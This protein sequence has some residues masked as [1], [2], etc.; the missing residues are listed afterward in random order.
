MDYRLIVKHG[1]DIGKIFYIEKNR[2]IIGRDRNT[3]IAVN[4]NT[5]SR[6]HC[7][8]SFLDDKIILKDIQSTNKSRVNN[9]I[10]NNEYLLKNG[11][12]IALGQTTLCLEQVKKAPVLSNGK[13]E[14]LSPPTLLMDNRRV[15]IK[16]IS[17]N[18]DL[19]YNVNS[20]IHSIRDKKKLIRIL[21]ELVFD[22]IPAEHGAILIYDSDL[23]KLV[24]QVGLSRKTGITEDIHISYSIAEMTFNKKIGIITSDALNDP[25]FSNKKTII[26]RSI[27]SA[28]CAPIG[29][30]NKMI[31]VIHLD[32]H[33]ETG[34]F[35]E[36]DLDLLSVIANQA[37][38]ALEN[39]NFFQ[40]LNEKN[41][42]LQKAM[43]KKYNMIGKSKRIKDI[44]AVIDRLSQNE[45]TILI[46]G[47][48]GTGKELVARAIHYTSIR[49]NKS[50]VCVNCAALNKNLLESEL[51]GHERG[52]FTGA[53][54]QLK[55]RFEI[56]AGGTIFLDEIGEL[57][58]ESQ[59]KL[60]RVIEEGKFER[61][62]G[63]KSIS[64]DVRIL[65]AT[66]KNLEKA[67]SEKLF[68]ED[69]YYRL[70]VIQIDL[71]PLRERKED[72]MPLAL[73]FLDKYSSETGRGA[74]Q[75]SKEASDMLI[76]YKWPGNI[77][78]LKNCIERVV[79]LGS[80]T[81][82][83]PQDLSIN[84]NNGNKPVDIESFPTLQDI[85]REHIIKAL[86]F[87]DSNKKKAAQI[88]GIQRS[89]LYEKLKYYNICV[90]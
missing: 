5:V 66:N 81:V 79:V 61:V 73:Y 16:T 4:D 37:A 57:N 74:M 13:P 55:G 12:E 58:I 67:I 89:T 47:E 45:S 83:K 15:T 60:L 78:E 71:P 9:Q 22:V 82:I 29:T 24:P 35:S 54:G 17:S 31:G 51:F 85:E 25:R 86:N 52:A 21:L 40:R 44:F 42:I 39:I 19:L 14:T 49:K 65:A 43:Q 75:F 70:K 48:S 10:V 63:V 84:I 87:T 27:R 68:R 62:G 30:V 64:T 77:R 90:E 56:A 2:I 53:V 34:V 6:T 76:S 1:P 20:A 11:D 41:K 32:N 7:E 28:M 69:L 33:A 38:I 80:S 88:L 18:L 59:V 46:C 72:I 23:K 36:K 26:L 8:I 3:D 50:L